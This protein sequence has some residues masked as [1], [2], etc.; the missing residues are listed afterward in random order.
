MIT[1]GMNHIKTDNYVDCVINII[2]CCNMIKKNTHTHT[3]TH[4][5]TL[6]LYFSRICLVADPEGTILLIQSL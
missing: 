5:H 6:S 1:M 2:N 4:T 3:H